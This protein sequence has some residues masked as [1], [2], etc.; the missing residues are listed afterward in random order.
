MLPRF[1]KYRLRQ[2]FPGFGAGRWRAD[3]RQLFCGLPS[4]GFDSRPLAYQ[5]MMIRRRMFGKPRK[6]DEQQKQHEQNEDPQ[7]N[8]RVPAHLDPLYPFA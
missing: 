8:G 6:A 7:F 1:S 2:S 3:R 4:R 5:M